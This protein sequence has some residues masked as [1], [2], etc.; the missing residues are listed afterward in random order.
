MQ[1]S[2]RLTTRDSGRK[3]YWTLTKLPD[4]ESLKDKENL[5]G[6]QQ[7]RL[8]KSHPHGKIKGMNEGI[9]K[10]KYVFEGTLL[11][12]VSKVLPF[13]MEWNLFLLFI[14]FIMESMFPAQDLGVS[15]Y[16]F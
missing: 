12:F 10:S 6:L 8:G 13:T 4:K 16:V 7:D 9:T 1:L 3:W 11:L 5:I 2:A 15:W 14:C